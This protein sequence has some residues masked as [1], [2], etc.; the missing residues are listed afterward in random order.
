M[1]HQHQIQRINTYVGKLEWNRLSDLWIELID[2]FCTNTVV[3]A[4][5]WK[6]ST[7][8]EFELLKKNLYFSEVPDLNAAIEVTMGELRQMKWFEIDL[9][10]Q[11]TDSEMKCE[12]DLRQLILTM[13][14]FRLQNEEA[15]FIQQQLIQKYNTSPNR[16]YVENQVICTLIC[17]SKLAKV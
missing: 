7:E 14:E 1:D 3:F 9:L 12:D 2:E 8:R 13:V 15:E 6:K 11:A 17:M 10:T 4:Y 16:V 5:L